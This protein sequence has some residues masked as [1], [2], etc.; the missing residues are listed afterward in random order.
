MEVG[1]R[2]VTGVGVLI[3]GLVA[4]VFFL[5]GRE[6]TRHAVNAP[7]AVPTPVNVPVVGSP[8]PVPSAA[9][10]SPIRDYFARVAAI[11]EG[12]AGD[13]SSV[14][15]ELIAASIGGDS[16]GFDKLI[17]AAD[18]GLAKL[19]EVEPP[20]ACAEY[21]QKLTALLGDTVALLR[22]LTTALQKQDTDGLTGL[23]AQAGALQ[24]RTSELEGEAAAIKARY[25]LR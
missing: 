6:S 21:H 1:R 22:S 11:Q 10:S 8:P 25:G 23:A 14:A 2:T 24:Q 13:P 7:V 20:P 18:A 12:P 17:Q 15:N 3:V 4:A 5:L 16:S 19:R 9:S